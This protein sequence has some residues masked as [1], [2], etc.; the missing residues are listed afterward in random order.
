MQNIIKKL[1]IKGKI[2]TYPEENNADGFVPVP[3]KQSTTSSQHLLIYWYTSGNSFGCSSYNI[4]ASLLL[5][6]S[7]ILKCQLAKIH[8]PET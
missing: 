4:P 8:E 7:L 6:Q 2:R 5:T 3:E 1:T